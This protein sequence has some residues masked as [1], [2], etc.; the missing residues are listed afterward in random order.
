MERQTR[1][2]R[3]R[4]TH[5]EETY[6]QRDTILLQKRR[7]IAGIYGDDKHPYIISLNCNL[8]HQKLSS[9]LSRSVQWKIYWETSGENMI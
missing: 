3:N 4:S 2:Q 1:D 6:D 5:H 9:S 8:R 7:I